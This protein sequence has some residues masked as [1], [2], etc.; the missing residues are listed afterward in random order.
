LE[1]FNRESDY[2]QTLVDPLFMLKKYNCSL[3]QNVECKYYAVLAR[4]RESLSLASA[5]LP[6]PTDTFLAN[7]C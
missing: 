5:E 4:S 6:I 2:T 1:Q 7:K 3:L